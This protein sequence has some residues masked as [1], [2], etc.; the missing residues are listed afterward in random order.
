MRRAA[1]TGRIAWSAQTGAG[2]EEGMR[3]SR[4]SGKRR[5]RSRRRRTQR[6]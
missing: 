2:G 4:R 6:V 1:H 3:M 5:R